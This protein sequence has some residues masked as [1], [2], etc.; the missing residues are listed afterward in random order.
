MGRRGVHEDTDHNVDRDQK[1]GPAEKGT[2]EA[3]VAHLFS[4]TL[5]L[6]F[7]GGAAVSAGR[8]RVPA[9]TAPIDISAPA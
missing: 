3:H 2:D 1:A 7:Y 8:R 5:M 4:R 6:A 9:A